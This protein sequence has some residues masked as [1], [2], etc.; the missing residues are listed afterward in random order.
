MRAVEHFDFSAII[1]RSPVQVLEGYVVSDI[2]TNEIFVV[3]TFQNLSQ[4]N[5]R[6]L[7]IRLFLY[8]DMNVPYLKLPFNYSYDNLTFGIRNRVTEKQPKLFEWLFE[9]RNES[10]VIDIFESFGKATYI[11]IPET[12]FKKIELEI[13]GVKYGN[14]TDEKLNIIVANK[15]RRFSELDDEK[16]YA[17]SKVNIY[18]QAEQYHPTKVIPQKTESAWL[19]CCGYKNLTADDKCRV[20]KRDRDWQMENLTDDKLEDTVIQLKRESDVLL[21]NKTKFKAYK[22][23]ETDEEI[24][25]KIKDYEK[26]IQNLAE[27]ERI[28]ERKKKMIIP[29]IILFFGILYLIMY[30]LMQLQ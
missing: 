15:C 28:N 22:K 11:K 4:K 24:Q 30:L 9:G 27:Q 2:E 1:E 23:P 6:S 14:G 20:C 8:Q 17:F 7:D 12:Y 18:E 10:K 29:K 25:K 19:C 26:V 16:K 5:I 3:F 13:T 21:R